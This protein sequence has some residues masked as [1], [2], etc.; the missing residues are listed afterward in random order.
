MDLLSVTFLAL[1]G[2]YVLINLVALAMY[3]YDKMMAR[4]GDR[5]ISEKTLLLVALL[6]PFGA[7]AGMRWFRHKTRKMKFK[8]VPLFAVLHV[9]IAFLLLY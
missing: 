9:L 1:A 3:G 2:L 7:L 5:R 4:K 8:L 6:G